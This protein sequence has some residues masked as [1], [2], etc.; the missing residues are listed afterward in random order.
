MFKILV[1]LGVVA[2]AVFWA[3]GLPLIVS[4]GLV[5]SVIGVALADGGRRR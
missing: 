3:I 4:V 5:A 1:G 2:T